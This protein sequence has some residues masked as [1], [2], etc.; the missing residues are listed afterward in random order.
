M[1][2]DV[3]PFEEM[4]LRLLNGAHSSI[5]YLGL[6]A[7]HDT[8]ARPSAIRRS[9]ASSQALW[10]EAIPTLPRDAGLDPKDYVGELAERFDNTA[11]RPPHRA[12]RQ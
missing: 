11:L 1:V 12:D 5:A 9:A 8:V 10:A 6:L 7:G 3:G 4:K 2:R